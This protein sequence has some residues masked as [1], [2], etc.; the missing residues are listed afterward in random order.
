MECRPDACAVYDP[1]T[2]G[3]LTYTELWERAG[4]VVAELAR[5]GIGPGDLVGV[6]QNRSIDLVVGFL[7][8]L[9]TGA[10]Y[11][12]LDAMAPAARLEGILEESGTRLVMCSAAKPWSDLPSRIER[13]PVPAAAPS[14]GS[15]PET[16]VGTEAP[17]YVC[18]TSG[19][20]GRPKGVI[21]SHRAVLRLVRKP[22]FCSIGPGDRV[23]NL[24]N[25]AFDVTTFEIWNT[26]AVGGTV[27][28]LPSLTDVPID[29]WVAM[30]RDQRIDTMSLTTSLFHAVARERPDAFASVRTL[31][32]AGEQMDL[33]ATR[34]VLA[35]EPPKSLVNAYGPTEAT[36]FASYFEC[37]RESLAGLDRVPI[38]FPIQETSL[39]LLDEE[40]APVPCG[41]TGELC[42]GGPGVATG[43][44]ERAE[45]TADRFVT[46][47][48]TD[49]RIYRTGDL[50]RE[51][52]GGAIELL[53]RRDR[54]V[55]LRGFRIEL[56]EIERAAA[57]TGLVDSAFVEKVGEGESATLIGFVLPAA[58]TAQTGEELNR[59]LASSL[60]SYMLPSRW[61][62]LDRVPVNSTGKVDRARLIAMLDAPSP[63]A[64]P[65]GHPAAASVV[66]EVRR[67]W[68][69]VLD[70]PQVEPTDNFIDLGGDSMLA[71]RAT[72]MIRER[73]DPE[74]DPALV[75]LS[76][77]LTELAG[78]LRARGAVV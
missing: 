66:E 44:L 24:A 51:L 28:V 11:L 57:T 69:E 31:A 75:L 13:V 1:L 14:G 64:A 49:E 50:G 39:H 15:V 37:S 8:V 45:L 72:E 33:G 63:A 62:T 12:P 32:V 26:L 68:C 65:G 42:I 41:E 4:W 23:A 21:V 60:P 76:D 7:G 58:K 56:G 18:Y 16:A 74:A 6:G 78:Q 67:I 77:S 48:E 54:Q 27:V 53:G 2:G 20:T 70:V 55:K 17:A 47:P 19:S 40:L 36:T 34:R 3:A 59:V 43:Y 5:R 29:E 61:I 46:R 9:R 25:P 35:A 30:L 22:N 10:A 38:G 73:I 52:P 71:A